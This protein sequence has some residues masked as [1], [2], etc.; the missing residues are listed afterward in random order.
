MAQLLF[1]KEIEHLTKV[2]RANVLVLTLWRGVIIVFMQLLS[3]KYSPERG[4]IS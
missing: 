4:N 1:Y 3:S 2:C